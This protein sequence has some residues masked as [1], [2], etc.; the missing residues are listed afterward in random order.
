MT[1]SRPLLP[2][3]VPPDPEVLASHRMLRTTYGQS[4]GK[5]FFK[6]MSI[7]PLNTLSVFVRLATVD[8]Y[9]A[10]NVGT[11]M[12]E[13]EY[14]RML[15]T[16]NAVH[17]ALLSLPA[18]ELPDTRRPQAFKSLGYEICRVTAIIYSTAILWGLPPHRGWH[19]KLAH[20]LRELLE[21][22]EPGSEPDMIVWALCI[23]GLASN[24]SSDRNFFEER[25]RRLIKDKGLIAWPRIECI[26]A[27]FLWSR[28]ACGNGATM[29]WAAL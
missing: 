6:D 8:C 10:A 23:G 1:Q 9:M 11:K 5:G 16:R 28:R 25:L 18:A 4:P 19:Q 12:S 26:V 14:D 27:D 2:H 20:N 17:H 13:M 22:L 21:K 3:S 15:E 7:F 29:L 24:G